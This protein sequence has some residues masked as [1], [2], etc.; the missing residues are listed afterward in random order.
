MRFR[1]RWTE[2]ARI[3]L[4]DI[5]DYIAVRNPLAAAAFTEE[6]IRRTEVL[7]ENALIGRIA[8]EMGR[9]DIHEIL[10]GNYRIVFRIKDVEIH[11]LTVFEGHKR[12]KIDAPAGE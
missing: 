11:I 8:A 6:L 12:L 7:P 9:D 10:Y 3:D 2:R 4:I 5:G 1:V